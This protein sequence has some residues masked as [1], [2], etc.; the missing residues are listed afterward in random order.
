MKNDLKWEK[1]SVSGY[2][3]IGKVNCQKISIDINAFIYHVF[4][5]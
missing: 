2:S 1:I 3:D 5:V 4:Y